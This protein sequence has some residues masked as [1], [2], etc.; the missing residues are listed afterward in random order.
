MVET[1]LLHEE[2]SEEEKDLSSKKNT[3]QLEKISVGIWIRIFV[4]PTKIITQPQL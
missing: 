1:V 2:I 4:W 3:N